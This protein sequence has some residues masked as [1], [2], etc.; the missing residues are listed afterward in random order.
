MAS[1]MYPAQSR[2]LHLFIH[3]T[4]MHMHMHIHFIALGQEDTWKF[5][6]SCLCAVATLLFP[7][8]ALHTKTL[9]ETKKKCYS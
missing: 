4:F 9:A 5:T 2:V 3:S 7:S 8:G 1:E 6:R